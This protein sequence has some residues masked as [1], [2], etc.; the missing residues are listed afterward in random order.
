MALFSKYTRKNAIPLINFLGIFNFIIII[1]VRLNTITKKGR[2][3]KNIVFYFNK[4]DL[5]IMSFGLKEANTTDYGFTQKKGN[6]FLSMTSNK[7]KRQF[8]ANH[9]LF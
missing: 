6:F 8:G 9:L 2:K 1:V 3:G 7:K 4:N 5:I